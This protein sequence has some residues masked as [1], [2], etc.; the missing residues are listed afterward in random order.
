MSMS[1]AFDPTLD[2]REAILERLMEL[3]QGINGIASAWRNHGPTETGEL[4]VPRPA[5]LL[6]DGCAKLT[7][8]N[9]ADRKTV[10][11]PA[12]IFAMDPQI[13]VLLAN[14]ITIEN[15][16]A[17]IGPEVSGWVNSIN[18][19]ITNDNQLIDLVTPNGQITLSGF[20]TDLKVGRTVG[21]YGSWLMM[22][23][24]FRYPFF[25]PQ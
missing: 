7:Q 20:E 6:F 25:P 10:K 4:G 21:A 13:V 5:Y 11:M 15:N 3:G 16:P 8:P 12:A 17:P 9:I 18:S 1:P 2:R 23:Y 14:R 24:E 22:Q 19:M